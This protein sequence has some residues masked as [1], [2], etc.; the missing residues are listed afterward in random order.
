MIFVEQFYAIFLN[1]NVLMKYINKVYTFE[2]LDNFNIP[3]FPFKHPN[4][5][6]VLIPELSP[7]SQ[8]MMFPEQFPVLTR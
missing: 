8:P 2:N 1:F 3:E 6:N 7:A 4:L 5:V